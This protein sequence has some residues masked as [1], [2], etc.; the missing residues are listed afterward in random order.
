[1]TAKVSTLALATE[2]PVTLVPPTGLLVSNPQGATA[3]PLFCLFTDDWLILQTFVVQALQ[4]PIATGDFESKYG[5]FTDEQDIESCIAAMRTVQALSTTFGDPMALIKELASNP[6][7]L[8]GET[9]PQTL[10]TH[11]VWFATKLNQAATTFNQ[12]LLQFV[13][14][15]DPK[16]CGNPTKCG[17]L[18]KDLLTGTGGLQSTAMEMVTLSQN[19]VQVLAQFNQDLKPATATM[20]TFTSESSK[21]YNDVLND[22]NIDMANIAAYQLAAAEAYKLWRDLTIAAVTTSIGVMVVTGGYGFPVA[23]ALAG[24]L[25]DAA[26]KA[27]EAYD[28]ACQD[29][30]KAA[31]DEQKKVLL[32]GDL[33]GFNTSMDPVNKA[34]VNFQ[35]TLQQVTGVWSDISNNINTIATTFTPEQLGD[36]SYVMQ[37]MALDRAT[38]DWKAIAD[39]SQDYTANSLVTYQL[40]AF[41]TPLPAAA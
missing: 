40:H 37:A 8:Q 35:N 5:T 29:I 1:M 17:A 6:A 27:R 10:Y 16:V 22:I 18:L 9:P 19:L 12:T 33:S 3:P 13:Q 28:K 24:S 11:I 2:D 32:L 20:A 7:I 34:A 39:K 41:G 14:V 4:L 25:G 21:F 38:A 15:L 30:A 23:A 36:L 26:T 31:A